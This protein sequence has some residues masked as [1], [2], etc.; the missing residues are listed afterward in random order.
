MKPTL[1]LPALCLFVSQ[2]FSQGKA[3]YSS[4]RKGQFFLLWGWNRAAYT[5]S[6]I[7]FKG[8]DYDFK[9][10]KVKAHDRPSPISFHNYLQ[11]NRLT[12]PQTNFRIGYF[13][14]N[15]LAVSVGFD[16][17][18]YVVDQDQTVKM[19][20]VIRQTG[21]FKGTYHGD[22][23]ITKDFLTYEHTDGLNYINAEMEKYVNLYRSA[24]QQCIINAILG[25]GAGILLPRTDVKLLG[26]ERNDRYHLSGVGV[27]V[28]AGMQVVFFKHLAIRV[29]NKFGYINMPDVLLHKRGIPGRAKQAFFFSELDGM[30]GGTFSLHHKKRSVNRIK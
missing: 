14:R 22:K 19:D 20:G 13:I 11:L 8:D 27:T 28:K 12:F 21:P 18:K 4:V 9:L 23:A 17:M 6:T 7:S 2:A 10:N 30:I 1:L 29:E 5:K 25:G 3:R 26:Y 16:H 15:N 24:S